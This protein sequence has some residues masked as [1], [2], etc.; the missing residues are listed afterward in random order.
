MP[1][2]LIADAELR[3]IGFAAGAVSHSQLSPYRLCRIAPYRIWR[4]G[5]IAAAW[6][7]LGLDPDHEC[8]GFVAGCVFEGGGGG[9]SHC[10]GVGFVG[11]IVDIAFALELDAAVAFDGVFAAGYLPDER[12]AAGDADAAFDEFIL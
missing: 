12:F 7:R 9:E 8:G 3:R 1:M 11:R 5:A 6:R 10:E 2:P 4:K